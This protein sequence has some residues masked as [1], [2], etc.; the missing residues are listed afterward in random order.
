ML[1][2]TLKITIQ[3][4]HHSK[5]IDKTMAK[6]PKKNSKY[7]ELVKAAQ[8]EIY[9]F[10]LNESAY[11]VETLV[12]LGLSERIPNL[13]K[14]NAKTNGVKILNVAGTPTLYIKLKKDEDYA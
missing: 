8:K 4:N 3:K 10:E 2:S 7:L 13:I 9:Q 1:M 12:S 14:L 5:E 6:L 11:S